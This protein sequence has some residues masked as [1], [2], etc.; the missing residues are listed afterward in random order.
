MSILLVARNSR[1]DDTR[2]S[3]HTR[4]WIQ[5]ARAGSR[6][7]S[8]APRRLVREAQLVEERAGVVH[9]GWCSSGPWTIREL[10]ALLLHAGVE[11]PTMAD[12]VRSTVSPWSSSGSTG[13]IASAGCWGPHVEAH[14]LRLSEPTV[15]R[16]NAMASA[17]RQAQ[18]RWTS[19]RSS[20]PAAS[21][22][23]PGTLRGLTCVRP[24]RPYRLAGHRLVH[25]RS[26]DAAHRHLG[27]A[28]GL[29]T[30]ARWRPG[31]PTRH[32]LLIEQPGLRPRP[33]HVEPAGAGTDL[34]PRSLIVIPG[35][36]P[37]DPIT[38]RASPGRDDR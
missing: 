19:T 21:P 8:R 38:V 25:R 14:G 10:L 3:S 29:I 15:D 23:G 22:R 33:Q 16:D 4:V 34:P 32:A 17:L 35:A 26:P 5:T 28:P 6:P 27:A 12:F 7:S 31:R 18:H 36:A 11:V 1:C 9:P 24:C 13:S 2:L 20:L 37:P 30:V